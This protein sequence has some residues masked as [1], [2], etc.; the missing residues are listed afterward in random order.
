MP[1]SLA[2]HLAIG[3]VNPILKILSDY[4]SVG[5]MQRR[6]MTPR[7]ER[8]LKSGNRRTRTYPVANVLA[9]GW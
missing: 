7:R 1:R 6:P 4:L 8:E 5:M 9:H 3:F 2:G